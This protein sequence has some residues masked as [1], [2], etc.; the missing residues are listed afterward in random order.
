MLLI[1]SLIRARNIDYISEYYTISNYVNS[2][3][4]DFHGIPDINHWLP[5]DATRGI[6]ELIPPIMVRRRG[7]PRTRR[8]RNTMDESRSTSNRKCGICKELGHNRSSCKQNP[9]NR[10]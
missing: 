6:I 5:L 2:Y 9:E 1:L 7:Q 4:V 10:R 3:S 8:Y